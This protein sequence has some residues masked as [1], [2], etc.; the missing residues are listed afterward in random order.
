MVINKNSEEYSV[1]SSQELA[2]SIRVL[3]VDDREFIRHFISQLI[4]GEPHLTIVGT[5][6]NGQNA[7]EQVELLKPDVALIDIEMPQMDGITATKIITRKFDFCKV[8]ILSSHQTEDYLQKALRTGAK[9]YL[10]KDSSAVELANAIYSVYKGYTQ[11]SPGLLEKVLTPEVEIVSQNSL[12]TPTLDKQ[13]EVTESDWAESTRE[14]I[15]TLPRVSLRAIFY[16]IVILLAGVIPWTMLAK[17][18]EIG[19]ATGKLEPK[20]RVVELDA[21]ANGTVVEIAVEEGET[22]KAQQ[23]IMELDSELIDSELE[24]QRQKIVGQQNQLNQLKLLQ[25]QQSL[26]LGTQE[27]QNQAQQFEKKAL[28]DQARQ[29][30][31]SLKAAY[32]AQLA[33]KKAQLE[34]A[35]EAIKASESAHQTAK[36]RAAAAAEKV[37]R[38]RSAY[39]QGALSKDL[40]SE[41][42]QQAKEYQQNITQ[43]ASEIAQARA[44]YIEQQ[45]GYEKLRQQTTAEIEQAQLR[46]AEQQRGLDSLSK[47]NSLAVLKSQEEYKNTKAQIASLEGEIAQTNSL[48]KGAEYR[49]QQ[50]VVYTPIEGTVFQLPI[51]KPGAVVQMGQ[52]IAQIA[53]KDSQLI[54]RGKMRSQESGFLEV[55]L[56]VKIKFDAYPFQDYGVIPGRLTWISPD[57]RVTQIGSSSSPVDSQSSEF[58]EVEIEL[59]RNYIETPERTIALTPGQAATAEIIIRQRRLADIILEPFKSLQKGGIQL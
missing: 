57:S 12:D 3:L 28:I 1:V 13:T 43:T 16:T 50:R 8:L 30:V 4:S 31:T 22:V 46:L 19:T 25:N 36:I 21:P 53:P 39:E 38:Y 55:G 27:Q 33:E 7:I 15:D 51:K 2:R 54:L 45:N 35:K 47:A 26:S 44:A 56:P 58:F 14:A 10:T 37:P 41:A 52:M 34:Q 29:N 20:G 48:I 18:D 40:L 23:P 42:Q 5:A 17:V 11:L 59:E 32:E 9:G 6:D 49:M 24:Q